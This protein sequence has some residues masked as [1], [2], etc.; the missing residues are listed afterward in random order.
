MCGIVGYVG[1]RNAREVLISGLAKLEYRGYDS[2]G[3]AV[4]TETG[5]TVRKKAGKLANL[6]A[7]LDQD[8]I[9]GTL[10][11][12]HTRWA[13]HGLPND[14]NAHPHATEDGRIVII[15][16]GIIE[17]YLPLKEALQERGHT[18]RSDTDSEVLAHLI[19]EKYAQEDG[20]LERAVR[21][22]LKDVRGAY[23]IVVTHVDHQEI[24]AART[25]S[26]LVMGVGEGEM[27]LASDVPALL[28]YTRDMVYLHDGDLVVLHQD[29]YHITTL[30]GTPVQREVSHIDWDAEAA[31]KG[32]FDTY[33]LKEIHEQPQAL[34]NTLMGRL[35]D[36]T[37]EVRL[38]ITL[39]PASFDRVHIVA[40][41][42]AYYAGLVGEYLIEQLARVP[43]EVDVASEYRY[44]QPIVDERTLVI[45]VS[46][47]GETIDTLEALREAKKS[48]ARTLGVINAKGSSMTREVDD[49]LYIHA[50]PE[51][52]VASTK[53]YTS[54]VGAMLL[55]ALW[56]GRARGTLATERGQDLLH[57]A[58]EL[59]RL[60]EESLTPERVAAIEAVAAKYKD[61]R[62]Y[63]FLGRGVNAPTAFEGALKL[64][65][66]SYIHAEAYAAG[67]MKHGPIALI[68]AS[69]PVVVIATE[70]VLLEKTISNIQE[71]RAR[72][73]RVIALVSEGDVEASRHADDVIVVPRADE[74]VSPVVNVVA[75]QLL[76]YFTAT[77]L[78]KDVDKPRNLAK[79]VTVE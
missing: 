19:E 45:V 72:A 10:G 55:L 40:C 70:S 27:F 78:G 57:A 49:T 30:D 20:H 5:L 64:K 76:S 7:D 48:G 67:E 61:A 68:D 15:H 26:P 16:N 53:A 25:V 63:L 42:T 21:A 2:A 39:D 66:I 4:R 59:P 77:L 41:G 51:I 62:D 14:R 69:L 28:P 37:G 35:H 43:V 11:I 24:V 33:M 13:T 18:F 65:E 38:D 46:Q 71:V 3:V 6:V 8:Q 23:G 74:M 79:S 75:L 54:M 22:A 73:G 1:Y 52:G 32:G 34:T 44:R 60:V 31:E 58:R 17:N 56:L 9:E 12:G 29:G 50:G 36:E 47:S